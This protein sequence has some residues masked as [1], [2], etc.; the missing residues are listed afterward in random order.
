MYLSA[1]AGWS[2]ST[3]SDP[4]GAAAT[5]LAVPGTCD[6]PSV[7]TGMFGCTGDFMAPGG[8][9]SVC[10]IGGG[11]MSPGETDFGVSKPGED[12]P[13]SSPEPPCE[14]AVAKAARSKP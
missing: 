3:Q 9:I 12:A 11:L 14:H 13:G 1:P 8:R 10:A 5:A 2:E 6:Q 7:E 4:S